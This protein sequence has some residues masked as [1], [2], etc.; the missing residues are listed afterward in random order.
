MIILIAGEKGG[1][2]KSTLATNLAVGMALE[3]RDVL[4]LDADPQRTAAQWSHR[5]DE[6]GIEPPV[7]CAEKTGDVKKTVADLANRYEDIVIDAGGRDSAE[8][9]SALLVAGLAYIPLRPSQADLETVPHIDQ[10]VG[11]AQSMRMDEGPEA[12]V[13]LSMCPTHP[14]VTETAEAREALAELPH[15]T[16]SEVAIRERKAYRDVLAQGRGV[17]ESG[18]AAAKF[19]IRE[20]M[21]EIGDG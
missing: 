18:N 4:L 15:L 21:K 11:L 7:P 10:L 5:R 14:L 3:G 2:G 20:L 19:D 8:L 9:R 17:L 1:S 13:I 12:R 16:L 6:S